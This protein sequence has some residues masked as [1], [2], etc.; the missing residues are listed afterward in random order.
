M[1]C[2]KSKVW[3]IRLSRR[4]AVA[5]IDVVALPSP[6]STIEDPLPRD[7]EAVG[8]RGRAIQ[9]FERRVAQRTVD[10]SRRAGM[11][12]QFEAPQTGPAG[13]ARHIIRFILS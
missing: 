12:P 8:H 3:A 1:P 5:R 4:R 6:R 10:V 2:G 11:Q 13:G 7:R 9:G